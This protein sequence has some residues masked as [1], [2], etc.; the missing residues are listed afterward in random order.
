MEQAFKN[1]ETHIQSD[2]SVTEVKDL[3]QCSLLTKGSIYNLQGSVNGD[4]NSSQQVE[5][6]TVNGATIDVNL[7]AED[8]PATSTPSCNITD[9]FA[10]IYANGKCHSFKNDGDKK[11]NVF[12][13]DMKDDNGN[14]TG[15]TLHYV[16]GDFQ[17]PA[18]NSTKPY[19]L[20][21]NI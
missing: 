2:I 19:D 18:G 21:V 11:D 20:L 10:H 7:C 17:C 14:V 1:F 4:K 16:G 8:I 3:K 13:T 5:R 9:S 15:V 6:A 12:A